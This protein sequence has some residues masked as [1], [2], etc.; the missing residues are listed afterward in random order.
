MWLLAGYKMA[1]QMTVTINNLT[2][3][4]VRYAK[5]V[6]SYWL[7]AKPLPVLIARGFSLVQEVWG[8]QGRLQPVEGMDTLHVLW[9]FLPQK[10]VLQKNK[11]AWTVLQEAGLLHLLLLQKHCGSSAR[12]G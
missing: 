4:G 6:D 2:N 11:S 1:E 8:V 5:N 7:G 9:L 12:E 3:R 10:K